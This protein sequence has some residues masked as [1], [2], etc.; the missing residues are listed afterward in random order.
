MT[1]QY[2]LNKIEHDYGF[3]T[4]DALGGVYEKS[5]PKVRN[6]RKN[7]RCDKSLSPPY[8]F[9]YFTFDWGTLHSDPCM[10]AEDEAIQTMKIA[11]FIK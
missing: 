9:V 1:L 5:L 3:G 2:Y 6:T 11:E 4:C 7:D 10:N 8:Y